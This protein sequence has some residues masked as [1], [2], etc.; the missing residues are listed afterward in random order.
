MSFFRSNKVLHLRIRMPSDIDG[1]MR[2]MDIL[3]KHETESLQFIDL[4]KEI[5]DSQK[6]FSKMLKRVEQME[7]K[8]TQF[9]NY[10]SEFNVKIY[11]YKNYEKFIDD[12][13]N[14]ISKKNL[15]LST[16][17]DNLEIEIVESEK[18]IMELIESHQKMKEEL[19]IEL[20]KKLV[21]E[22]YFK[23]TGGML[24][25]FDLKKKPNFD[26]I[27]YFMGVIRADNEIKMNRMILRM[28]RGRAISTFFDFEIPQHLIPDSHNFSKNKFILLFFKIIFLFFELLLFPKK[29]KFLL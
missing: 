1:I 23:M 7:I 17:F 19:I 22:K 9:M 27:S 2:I 20:E 28:G 5:P 24:N 18:K 8:T 3:G 11:F 13:E 10:A 26:S 14:D 16:Y 15:S 6:S 21:F 29:K 25:I 12:I 4:T